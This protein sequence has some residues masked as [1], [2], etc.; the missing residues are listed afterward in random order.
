[1]KVIPINILPTIKVRKAAPTQRWVEGLDLLILC[2]D[3]DRID[4][5]HHF[6]CGAAILKA[7]ARHTARAGSVSSEL[8]T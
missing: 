8:A 1:M 4:E 7:R 5:L 3:D 6:P 2:V